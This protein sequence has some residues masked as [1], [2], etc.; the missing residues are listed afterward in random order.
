MSFSYSLS[1]SKWQEIYPPKYNS[2]LRA[3]FQQLFFADHVLLVSGTDFSLIA[4]NPLSCPMASV[5]TR[6]FS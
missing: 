5:R 4:R 6:K 2:K 3:I 1:V